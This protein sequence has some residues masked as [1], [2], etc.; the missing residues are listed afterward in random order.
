MKDS[1]YCKQLTGFIDKINAD[2][3]HSTNLSTAPGKQHGDGNSNSTKP[4]CMF[5]FRPMVS[6]KAVYMGR[7]TKVC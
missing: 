3:G 2:F 7:A 1:G 5:G 6:D 4:S